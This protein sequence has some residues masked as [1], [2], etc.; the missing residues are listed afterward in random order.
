M[1]LVE[2]YRQQVEIIGRQFIQFVHDLEY[3]PYLLDTIEIV[4]NLLAKLA[5]MRGNKKLE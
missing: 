4:E 5:H 2:E 1:V 3:K